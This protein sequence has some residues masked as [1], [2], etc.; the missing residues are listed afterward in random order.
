MSSADRLEMEGALFFWRTKRPE[1][2]MDARGFR[3][4]EYAVSYLP[5][6]E[7]ANAEAVLSG[8]M[9]TKIEI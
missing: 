6:S 9:E 4:G 1:I 5:L 3:G 7:S 2:E 8:N